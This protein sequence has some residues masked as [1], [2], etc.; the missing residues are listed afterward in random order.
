MRKKILYNCSKC[1]HIELEKKNWKTRLKKTLKYFFIAIFMF[2][3]LIG[4]LGVYN[5]ISFG[6]FDKPDLMFQP[7]GGIANIVSNFKLNMMTEKQRINFKEYVA[8]IIKDCDDEE[9]KAKNIFRNL[10][11]FSYDEGEDWNPENILEEKE[12][13]CDEMSLLYMFLLKS[14]KIKSGMKC[15]INH[16]WT[17]VMLKDKKIEAD[18]VN[19]IWKEK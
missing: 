7:F 3:A 17:I 16:C 11:R 1:G 18:V 10:T 5:L 6:I 12:G 9:C 19:Y 14:I 2:F 8:P 4:I 13:D 15:S